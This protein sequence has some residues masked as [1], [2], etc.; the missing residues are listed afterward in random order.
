MLNDFFE[1]MI[2][3]NKQQKPPRYLNGSSS[4]SID[5]FEVFKKTINWEPIRKAKEGDSDTKSLPEN[6]LKNIKKFWF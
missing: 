1:S 5:L 3:L 6:Y 4:Y 2:P